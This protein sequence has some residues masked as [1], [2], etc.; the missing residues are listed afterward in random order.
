VGQ[1]PVGNL[2]QNYSGGYNDCTDSGPDY[3]ETL[4][5]PGRGMRFAIAKV[6]QDRDLDLKISGNPGN[7]GEVPFD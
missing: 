3:W 7:A 6:V 4:E 2:S 1:I 5:A